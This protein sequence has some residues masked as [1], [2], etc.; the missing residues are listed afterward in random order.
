MDVVILGFGAGS[1]VVGI[2]ELIKRLF[3]DRMAGRGPIVAAIIVA[4]VLVLG[5]H[6]AGIYPVFA[7]WWHQALAALLVGLAAM[8]L[9]DAGKAAV[10]GR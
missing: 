9:F 10:A 5:E 6:A 2:V 3:P 8:G 4:E 1:L 7:E